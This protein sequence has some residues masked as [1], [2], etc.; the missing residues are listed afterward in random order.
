MGDKKGILI[1]LIP[2][3]I[4]GSLVLTSLPLPGL[5]EEKSVTTLLGAYEF[6]SPNLE[7]IEIEHYM[8]DKI[9]LDECSLIGNPGE[10]VLP[11]KDVSL[12]IPAG[13]FI[14]NIRIDSDRPILLGK[15]FDI[16]PGSQP[17][18][19]STKDDEVSLEK[20]PII[21]NSNELYPE[22]LFTKTGTYIFRG[23][24]ILVGRLYPIQYNPKTGELFYF[25]AL[26]LTL[27]LEKNH[28][29]N[30]FYRNQKEDRLEIQKKV[31]NPWIVETYPNCQRGRDDAYDLLI[32]TTDEL[33]NNF[34][35]LKI[36]HNQEGI[37]TTIRTLTD[38]GG[39]DPEDIRNYIRD[40]YMDWGIEYVLLGG[41]DPTFPARILWVF[42]LDENTTPY[43]TY[44]PSDIYYGCLDGPY[45]FDGD[46]KWG[47]PTDGEGG[48]DVDLL[49]EVY[50]G[51]ACVDAVNDVD[52][53][54]NKTI[55]YMNTNDDYLNDVLMAGEYL[56]DYGI[57]SYGGNYLD[58]LINGS[59]DDGYTTVGVPDNLYRIETLYERDQSWSK[60][61][62][63]ERINQ[64]SHIINHLGHSSYDYNMK[65]QNSDS[66]YLTNDQYC[67]VYSQGCNAGG[68]DTDDCIAEYLTAKT[69]H[70]A[71]A[72]IWNARYGWFWSY[73]TDGDS[74]GF[75]RQF[76][77]AIFG[78]EIFEI[79]KANQDSK[80]DNLFIIDRSCIRWC[81]YQL[82]LFGD[83][84]IKLKKPIENEPP[85]TPDT[86]TGPSEGIEDI[87]Y[88]FSTNPVSDPE[89]NPVSYLFDWGDGS[90]SGWLDVPHASHAWEDGGVFEVKVKAKDNYSAESQW[91]LPHEIIIEEIPPIKWLEIISITGGKGLTV[92]VKNCAVENA[93][94]I[95]IS[96]TIE[97]GLF[98]YIPQSELS[99]PSLQPG[100]TSTVDILVY[101]IGLGII[102]PLPQLSISAKCDEWS[103]AETSREAKILASLILL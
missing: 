78:E 21:Y 95:I 48:D 17:L 76:W 96:L 13:T 1:R 89:G 102:T 93:T 70:G 55:A 50:I 36:A 34:E 31:D 62:I 60:V 58:Q 80:E 79:G 19:I 26:T 18:P 74:Q 44:L 29:L 28:Y 41:D 22:S 27:E 61:D 8:Y 52:F 75:H 3:F 12:L 42:G 47:E 14:K 87:V 35:P 67:F 91:S 39:D 72:G 33:K 9:M 90:D 11:V 45:N 10:P 98:S 5:T 88:N 85:A 56:G 97:G 4:V 65:M 81:Y 66:Y 63:M 25:S 103:K 7:K 82:N 92:T 6:S 84:A 86:P 57:A 73:S 46:D 69:D 54:V 23:Y 64:G 15:D 20:N 2:L 38:V 83:P 101:G 53:F 59:S 49:A 94:N 30:P 40:A 32:L 43:E 77:D 68:F 51:R 24:E 99:I 16:L 100:E 71:F 37:I